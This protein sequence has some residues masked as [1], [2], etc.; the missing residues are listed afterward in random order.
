MDWGF[1]LHHLGELGL[2]RLRIERRDSFPERYLQDQR[3][4]NKIKGQGRECGFGD[5]REK[6]QVR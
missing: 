3:S 6:E 2:L 4:G 1:D 5:K